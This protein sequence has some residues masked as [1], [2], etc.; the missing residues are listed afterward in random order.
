M[1]IMYLEPKI[2]P[3]KEPLVRV[4]YVFELTKSQALVLIT[5][6]YLEPKIE[7]NKTIIDISDIRA[8][9]REGQRRWSKGLNVQSKDINKGEI[10]KFI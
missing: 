4:Y 3:D 5:H 1:S 8:Q 6:F 9:V 7:P 2:K 10:S